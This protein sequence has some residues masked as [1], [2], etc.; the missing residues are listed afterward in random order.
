MW[1]DIG[2]ELYRLGN[3][4]LKREG[5]L[6]SSTLFSNGSVDGIRCKIQ[7]RSLGI[8]SVYRA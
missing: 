7:V 2:K 6:A 3:E 4:V 5:I 8:L 1:V